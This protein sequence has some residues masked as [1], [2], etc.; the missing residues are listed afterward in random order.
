MK[1]DAL[2]IT[3]GVLLDPQ[4]QKPE[5]LEALIVDGLIRAVGT[6]LK[7]TAPQAAVL[8]AKGGY[9]APN[10]I[11]IH[12]HLREPKCRNGDAFGTDKWGWM[13]QRQGRGS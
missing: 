12:V 2:L 6:G 7:A 9:V 11:D 3:N 10:L 4:R 8:D 5:K 13:Q 1:N